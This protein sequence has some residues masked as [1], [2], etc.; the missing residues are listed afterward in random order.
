MT[1][2]FSI[3]AASFAVAL[4]AAN[5]AGAWSRPGH[6][7]TAAIAFDDLSAH[8]PAVLDTIAALLA[9]HPD[10]GPFEV[11]ADRTSGAERTLRLMME[12]ARWPDDQRGTPFD[13]PTWHYA[14]VAT[15]GAGAPADMP[16][17]VSGQA[18]E[19]LRL[20]LAEAGDP[21][22]PVA[23]RALALCWVMHLAG[24]I[25]QPLHNSTLYSATY[26]QGD[27]GGG[28]QFVR[29]PET[30]TV[31]SLH[32]YWDDRVNKSADPQT[33]K[34]LAAN[35]ETRFPRGGLSELSGP[36]EVAQWAAESHALAVQHAYPASLATATAEANAPTVPADYAKMSYEISSRRLALGGYRLA[37]LLRAIA[38]APVAKDAK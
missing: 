26:P 22:A 23:D 27:A 6:M 9:R 3:A 35:I 2:P 5:P 32:W 28:K 16:K 31:V 20:T 8:D 1:R 34:T 17:A 33:I 4:L 19:A 14:E 30:G 37:D 21:L 13:H 24:D 15:A 11:A 12:C 25:Q 10:H 29:D 7:L 18:I 36:Q 38:A